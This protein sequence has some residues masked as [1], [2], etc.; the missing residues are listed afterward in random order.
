MGPK[1]NKVLSSAE[2][3]GL[4]K[5]Y[6][7]TSPK[8]LVLEDLAMAMGIVVMDGRLD[9][10]AA[11]LVR[12]GDTGIV[13]IS[14]RIREPGRR[15]FAIAHEIGHWQMHRKQSYL[16]ACTD[17]D[18]LARYGA[19]PLEVEAS[20]FAGSLLMPDNLFIERVNGRRPTP[21]VIN[22]LCDY[23]GTTLTATALR[24]VETSND[25]YI[26][27][28]SENNRIRWWRASNSFGDHE[29][30]IENK[31][32]LP[33]NSA[34]AS[35]FRGENVPAKPQHLDFS[36]WLGD[37]PNIDSETIIEQA[38]PLPSYDQVISILWLPA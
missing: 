14:H 12:S 2:A 15:R 20:V 18:M 34:A 13:R 16:L 4:W 25:Y 5:L 10:A 27:V 38:F 23:F 8:E 6:G 28:L 21:N 9:S 1:A 31:T 37:L 3:H 32:M 22:D 17:E 26:F 30:W 36:A 29:L 24:Y 11:R 19:S 33:R 7:F 35:F